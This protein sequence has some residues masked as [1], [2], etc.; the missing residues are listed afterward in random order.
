MKVFQYN[1]ATAAAPSVKVM[2]RKVDMERP[3]LFLKF[4]GT[5]T[6]AELCQDS[7]RFKNII[8]KMKLDDD[9]F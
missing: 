3:T 6:K 7:D 4:K 2:T 1:T 5:F 8:A 9:D